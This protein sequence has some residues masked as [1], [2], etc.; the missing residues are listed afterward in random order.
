MLNKIA[1]KATTVLSY[2]PDAMLNTNSLFFLFGCVS[3][4][5]SFW[6]ERQNRPVICR[7]V[8]QLRGCSNTEGS[9]GRI[10]L[11]RLNIRF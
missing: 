7:F 1:Q 8:L 3:D 10:V 11:L 2:F 5:I 4:C 6:G 9:M